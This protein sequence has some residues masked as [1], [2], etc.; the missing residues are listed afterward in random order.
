MAFVGM[1]ILGWALA[2]AIYFVARGSELVGMPGWAWSFWLACTLTTLAVARAR[3]GRYPHH[4]LLACIVVCGPFLVAG[5]FEGG[6]TIRAGG[7]DHFDLAASLQS[8]QKPMGWL[9]L[10][11][12]PVL[13]LV[14][15]LTSPRQL[16]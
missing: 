14:G 3:T 12:A 11:V 6:G 15:S 10:V 16:K 4:V 13:A 9:A 7:A 8:F 5:L 1:V 2:L